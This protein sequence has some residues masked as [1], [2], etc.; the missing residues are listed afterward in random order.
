MSLTKEQA[1]LRLESIN[2]PEQLRALIN[3]LDVT[4]VGTTT[5][6]W[7]GPAGFYGG[8]NPERIASQA[9]VAGLHSANPEFRI[10]ANT[11]A[12]KFLE[13]DAS[14][15]NYN[16]NLAN[17]LDSMFSGDPEK[18]TEFLY[19]RMDKKSN[20]RLTK[21]IWDDVSENFVK[22]AKGDVRLVVGG[23]GL[24]RVFAQT[25][26][27]AMLANPAIK[28][29]E[30]VSIDSLRALV[31]TNGITH[32]TKL[33]MAISEATTGM[34]KMKVDARGNPISGMDGVY[35]LDATDYIKMNAVHTYVPRGMRPMT[36][37]I[38]PERRL[39]HSHSVEDI[40]RFK[41]I[42]Q[43]SAS[44]LARQVD[45]F[46]SRLVFSRLASFAGPIADITSATMMM[47]KATSEVNS[48]NFRDAHNTVASWAL[49]TTGSL[50]AGRVATLLVAPL[51]ATGPV[52]FIIGAGIIIG[53]SILGG[54]LAKKLLKK[55]QN[56]IR[57]K[58][59]IIIEL[60]S[61]LALDLDGNG[62][63][64]LSIKQTYINFDHD[65]NGFAEQTG[66]LDPNDGLLILDLNDNGQVDSG[67]ELF[68]D[69]TSLVNGELAANGFLA[70]A[71][72]DLN[73]D[74]RIDRL[75][76]VWNRLRVWRDQN[77]N[78]RT[79]P[80][81]WLSMTELQINALL[82]AYT[83]KDRV[84]VN[85]NVHRHHGKFEG[86]NGQLST[87]TDVW[88]LKD[89]SN[90]LPTQF[91]DVDEETS[92]LP[93][94]PGMGIVQSLHQAL[95]DPAK[96]SLRG[97]LHQWLESTRRQRMDIIEEFLFQ[98]VDADHNP[99]ASPDRMYV[100]DDFLIEKKVAVIEKLIGEMLAGS[101]FIV[102][103]NRANEIV[104]LH[105]EILVYVDMLLNLEVVVKPLMELAI[106]VES[107]FYGPLQMDLTDSIAHLRTHFQR[108]PDPAFVPM[109]QWQL[110]HH[111][112][113]GA[114]FFKALETAAA[115]TSDL[116][117]RA[118]RLQR[119]ITE[120]WEWIVGSS[121]FDQ[122]QGTPLND[123]IEAGACNDHIWGN[124]GDD[125]LHGG[126]EGDFY[127]GG[128]GG[129]TYINMHSS[130]FWHDRIFDESSEVNGQ[131]DRL[132]FWDLASHQILPV[133]KGKD[134][135]F[136][137]R[138][139]DPQDVGVWH[140]EDVVVIKEQINPQHRIEEFH[141]ADG[142][143]WS[144]NTLLLQLPILGT[145]G[146]DLLTGAGNDSNRFQ[147]AGGNDTLIGGSLS[148]HLEGQQGDDKLTGLAAA[149]TLSGGL[150]DDTLDGGEGGDCYLI[151]SNSG[152]D[153][154]RNFDRLNNDVDSVIFTDLPTT[155]LTR[156]TRTNQNLRLQFGSNTSLTLVNQMESFSRIESF[157]F[158]DGPVWDHEALLRQLL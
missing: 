84:D 97:I 106:P 93:D 85:G 119:V 80:G 46:S 68:G 45:P 112:T 116:L 29:I 89:A 125:T 108:D 30:G 15:K 62:I 44:S 126:M 104:R 39:R 70:L 128:K 121:D 98:W 72:Y 28:S 21:G 154:I 82:L 51:M 22:L 27:Q 60:S 12:S 83:T 147:G 69:N 133:L 65:N 58:H 138:E 105:K 92:A 53:A 81:E 91:R 10:V 113:V 109:V 157:V 110:A 37:F 33:L 57:N 14:S 152:H 156:V 49:E 131:P 6:L 139:K 88:F 20:I 78:G 115:S 155:A 43:G 101:D 59:K 34:I 129:D 120:P 64:T 117:L 17:K 32:V 36:D 137:L 141:F 150:G 2:T 90:S 55:K 140:G 9:V 79:D 94:I 153:R 146:D 151:S 35:K 103:I 122:L 66:W 107:E 3:E 87:L 48:G 123:F 50:A 47:T 145:A 31:K 25:E 111:G 7:S 136:Q 67:A 18:I 54:D 95:M 42:L 56:K 118:F 11:E 124:E 75:D 19:G 127:Y 149:D 74:R 16:Q 76:P 5:V 1:N 99:F 100:S 86:L 73:A 38:P 142:V 77:S 24:D 26:M 135:A 158:A 71:T 41:Q 130:L 63:Q 102:A 143:V 23:G 132:V 144:Y 114:S 148:D 61:P 96:T 4:G 52:G 8:K 13:L 40:H 134:V